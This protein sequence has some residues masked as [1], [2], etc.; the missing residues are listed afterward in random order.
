MNIQRT[1]TLGS[2]DSML[3]YIMGSESKYY[4]LSEEASS[5]YKVTKPS[6]DPEAAKSI[7]SINTQLNQLQSYLDN[8]SQSQTELNSLDDTLSS[9]TDV[10]T[11]ATDLAAQGAN[12]TYSN[13]DMDNI[14]TQIDQIIKSVTD[15]ANT[16][17]DGTYIFSGTA[18]A[19]KPFTTVTD[20]SGNITSITYN[21]TPSTS[22]YQRYVT[23]SDGVSFAIN[24]TGDQVFGSYTAA[25][26]GPPATPA[27]GSGLL[28]T[29]GKLSAGLGAHDKTAVSNS[30]DGLNTALDTVSATRTTFASVSNR[31]GLTADSINTTV[32]NL[33]SYKSDLQDADL[34]QVLADLSIQQTALQASYGVFSKI[35]DM[36]LLNYM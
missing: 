17:Y 24:T 18:T 28:L 10:I 30:L 11:K 23:I 32:I 36:S 12:G 25:T 20:A 29:L 3:G 31:F 5:G 4:Q 7:L 9:V 6:D 27:T 13:T 34:S 2:S 22:D 19:T 35:S 26:V 15:L 21:G 14:K 33:K 8:M 16:Q 1:T